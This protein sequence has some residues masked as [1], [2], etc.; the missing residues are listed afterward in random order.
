MHSVFLSDRLSA[1]LILTATAKAATYPISI[2]LRAVPL[3]ERAWG[4]P[5]V[6]GA[7]RREPA[8]LL[9]DGRAPVLGGRRLQR[10]NSAD[11][12][13]DELADEF[14]GHRADVRVRVGSQV[15]QRRF[16]NPV[17]P[18]GTSV[19]FAPVAG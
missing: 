3:P 7:S 14:G 8:C 15:P 10:G 19:A 17:C 4:S 12:G 11:I 13:M 1:G 18:R 5:R 16:E 9:P 6:D 2:Q